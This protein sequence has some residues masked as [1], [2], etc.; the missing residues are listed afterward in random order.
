MIE[1]KYIDHIA[2]IFRSIDDGIEYFQGHHDIRYLYGPGY[3]HVQDV[4]FAF[5]QVKDIGKIEILSPLSENSPIIQRLNTFGPG[6]YH[7]CY[8]VDNIEMYTQK[9]VNSDGWTVLSPSKPDPAFD[10]RRVSFL[11][12]KRFGMIE[13]LEFNHPDSIPSPELGAKVSVPVIEKNY[14]PHIPPEIY[15]LIKDKIDDSSKLIHAFDDLRDW[16]S[17]AMA[18]FHT[19]FE[20]SVGN[21][22]DLYPLKTL[23]QYIDIFNDNARL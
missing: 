7:I 15:E 12:S 16:D 5:F 13:L 10:N 11:Y 19:S 6:L 8:C 23:Q 21:P 4:V 18:I 20:V 17:L 22:V 3:N 1:Y 14:N 2:Y 9:L